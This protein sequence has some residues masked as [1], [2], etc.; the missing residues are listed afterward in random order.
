MCLLGVSG[1]HKQ[2]HISYRRYELENMLI[3][4]RTTGN[5]LYIVATVMLWNVISMSMCRSHIIYLYTMCM[6]K[7]L[8]ALYSF[9]N[10]P[11]WK[12]NLW[13]SIK[14]GPDVLSYNMSKLH[15]CEPNPD[16][17]FSYSRV[18]SY[19]VRSDDAYVTHSPI[20]LD[21][22]TIR[23]GPWLTVEQNTDTAYF[24]EISLDYHWFPTSLFLLTSLRNTKIQRFRV[25]LQRNNQEEPI[26]GFGAT[27]IESRRQ[28]SHVT[29]ILW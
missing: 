5:I 6:S 2:S 24:F 4:Y 3:F 10:I 17:F 27:M 25:P 22:L 13:I 18:S 21:Q 14:N 26:K 7:Q 12:W 29:G 19:S 1:P 11:L 9:Q 8:K 20:D 15:I 16:R 23:S 28:P